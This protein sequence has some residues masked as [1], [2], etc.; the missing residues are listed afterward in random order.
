MVGATEGEVLD[1]LS[2]T[3]NP[4]HNFLF[5]TTPNAIQDLAAF[6]RTQ[7]VDMD[8]LIDPYTGVSLGDPVE[9][10]ELYAESCVNCHGAAGDRLN[11]GSQ[12]SPLFLADLAV[13]D[14]WQTVHKI[15]FGTPTNVN[16]PSTEELGW[17][18]ARVADVLAYAQT[19]RRA[20]PSL[21]PFTNASSGPVEVERQ[22]QIEP[23][24]WGAFMAFAII[25]A[26][27]LVDIYRERGLPA[28]VK[29]RRAR[30]TRR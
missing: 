8:L 15:R 10:R 9:G 11:F 6:L 13:S 24:I 1:W 4:T 17:S 22:G 23:L 12:T 3:I 2:G 18:L 30:K 28:W 26:T 14:P 20:N 16:M 21:T 29:P 5:Y 19:L 7:Q 27:V 25:A